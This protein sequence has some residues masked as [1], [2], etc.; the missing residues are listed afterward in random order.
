MKNELTFDYLTEIVFKN[1]RIKK[2][3]SAIRKITSDGEN[4]LNYSITCESE[5]IDWSSEEFISNLFTT[6][7]KFELLVNLRE[8]KTKNY[9]IP[10]CGF[11]IYR[12]ETSTDLEL[13]FQLA[14]LKDSNIDHLAEDLMEFSTSLARQYRINEYYCG[15]EPA[16]DLETRLFTKDK[17]G[18]I[19]LNSRKVT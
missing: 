16:Q 11:S 18:P 13:D 8:L 9:T 5:E 14:D 6:N 15:I 7:Q 10:K 12:Y 2:I 19:F 4:V 17:L 1:V 3:P